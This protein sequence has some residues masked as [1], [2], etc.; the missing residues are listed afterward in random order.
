MTSP[1]PGGDRLATEVGNAVPYGRRWPSYDY[2]FAIRDVGQPVVAA[3]RAGGTEAA[4]QTAYAIG[5][6]AGEHAG[7]LVGA[8]R[9]RIALDARA[10][11]PEPP[12]RQWLTDTARHAHG[13][14]VD[15]DREVVRARNPDLPAADLGPALRH[16]NPHQDDGALPRVAAVA[17][18]HGF[19]QGEQ[20]A[21]EFTAQA[22]VGYA[23]QRATDLGV[24]RTYVAEALNRPASQR[25]AGVG[26][27]ATPTGE[28]SAATV[29]RLSFAA[30][31]AQAPRSRPPGEAATSPPAAPG[32]RAAGTRRTR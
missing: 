11:E 22:I 6:R 30:S 15:A 3:Y 10:R 23:H 2:S 16:A 20:H 21:K 17:Y 12:H 8:G 32:R 24:D 7:Q 13:W 31:A 28:Q 18:S 29:A 19:D 26:Q 14:V 1:T 25:P 5:Y 4:A 27:A 9:L